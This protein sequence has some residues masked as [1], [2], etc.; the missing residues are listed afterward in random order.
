[1]GASKDAGREPPAPPIDQGREAA[2]S[3]SRSCGGRCCLWGCVGLTVVAAVLAAGLVFLYLAFGKPWF[4]E[5]KSEVLAKFP[6]LNLAI[7]T[8]T[9]K[10]LPE[11]LRT[12]STAREDFPGDIFVP[13]DLISAA[14]RTS[15]TRAVAHLR[16][17]PTDLQ[18]VAEVYRREMGRLGWRREPVP[19]PREGIRLRFVRQG[20]AARI[21]LR[22]NSD[23]VSVWIHRQTAQ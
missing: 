1:M 6:A 18:S 10:N 23:A 16:L 14:F 8:P 13:E 19:D 2:P 5:K 7:D 12:G 9:I 3:K 20:S 11:P 4:D 21:L 15:E 17:Q 22:Q